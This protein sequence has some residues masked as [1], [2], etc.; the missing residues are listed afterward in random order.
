[1]PCRF[2]E[3][4]YNGYKFRNFPKATLNTEAVKDDGGNIIKYHRNTLEVEFIITMETCQI[5]QSLT[6]GSVDWDIS[7]IRDALL[8]ANKSIKLIYRGM[9]NSTDFEDK[10]AE[11][12]FGGGQDCQPEVLTWEPLASNKAVRCRWRC[13]FH[14]QNRYTLLTDNN[15]T[16]NLLAAND[17]VGVEWYRI[18]AN[19]QIQNTQWDWQAYIRSVTE[20]QEV[21]INTE[22]FIELTL[23]GTIEF[24]SINTKTKTEL[25]NYAKLPGQAAPYTDLNK[26][27]E[28]LN[29]PTSRR[30]IAQDLARYF[31]PYLPLG[32][33]R[34]QRYVY[35]KT[36]RQLEYVI[37]DTEQVNPRGKFPRIINYTASH[38]VESTLTTSD[39]YT[40]PQGFLSWASSFK[41]SFTVAP[42]YW[43]G[44]AYVA[45]LVLVKQRILNSTVA[46]GDVQKQ[47]KDEVDAA[48]PLTGTDAQAANPQAR[49][50]LTPKHFLTDVSI[51]E[52]LHENKVDISLRYIVL[53]SLSDLFAKTGLFTRVRSLFRNNDNS[54]D[55]P[56]GQTPTT[57]P[58]TWTPQ[59]WNKI[60][61]ANKL[62][63]RIST[64]AVG[65]NGLGL[66][67][68]NIIFDPSN[69]NLP[70]INN[71]RGTALPTWNGPPETGNSITPAAANIQKPDYY[72]A[73][74]R[75]KHY[76]E[77]PL[78]VFQESTP[79]NPQPTNEVTG[80]PPVTSGTP[81]P[82]PY[83][84]K[85]TTQST[86]MQNLDPS[87]SWVDYKVNFELV[88]VSNASYLP[89]IQ[90]APLS[91]I[92]G[93]LDPTASGN[94]SDRYNTAMTINNKITATGA[95]SGQPDASR[96]SDHL[97]VAHGKPTYYLKFTGKA[98][99]I[100][101]RIPMPVV[102]GL[103]NISSVSPVVLDVYRVGKQ[104]WSQRQVA[105][106]ADMPV[107]E[108][109][110]SMTYAIQGDPTCTNISFKHLRQSEFV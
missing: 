35:N 68:Y 91:E 107:F 26:V 34:K 43:K 22:G 48:R 50:K 17:T 94:P 67:D 52:Q 30:S 88:E 109:E 108:A 47:V 61:S 60:L 106:S 2:D 11:T 46:V 18:P 36:Q 45:M 102:G 33:T 58:S 70:T 85:E 42:G 56:D 86:W 49:K 80:K 73:H 29:E 20:E 13:V 93:E 23:K 81:T 59:T 7:R 12:P 72:A 31:E 101:Y 32:F 71:D 69:L 64:N 97:V 5:V 41:G 100:G 25:K 95:V 4:E 78:G 77:H 38:T 90:A 40:Q 37:V 74:R 87:Q 54:A 98:V 53:T 3:I 83:P 55:L 1:M 79:T 28:Y 16:D 82:T 27:E 10:M 104:Y 51:T 6:D 99:R 84:G 62:H 9:G 57:H 24:S 92:K 39:S 75:Q 14:T 89:T 8:C 105:Q 15:V 63:D 65:Y 110:W 44:W 103:Q 19:P 76:V 96:Y 21:D 66:A